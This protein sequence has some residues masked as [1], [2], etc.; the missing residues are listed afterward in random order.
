MITCCM[1]GCSSHSRLNKH[2]SYNRLPDKKR[3][4][5]RN[6]L[7]KTINKSALLK[8]IHVCSIHSMEDSFDESQKLKWFLLVRN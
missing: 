1:K 6:A 3:K 7:I 4:D 5:K 8:A 2:V